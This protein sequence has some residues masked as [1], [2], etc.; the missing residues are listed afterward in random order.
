MVIVRVHRTTGSHVQVLVLAVVRRFVLSELD[1]PEWR[2]RTAPVLQPV[3]I[4]GDG[5]RDGQQESDGDQNGYERHRAVS[6]CV[7]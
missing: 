3:P 5:S 4:T 1:A 2:L 6:Q 7:I